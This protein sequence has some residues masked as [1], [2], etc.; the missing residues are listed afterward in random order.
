MRRKSD[1]NSLPTAPVGFLEEA[2]GVRSATRLVM[3]GLLLLATCVT[4]TLCAYVLFIP[5]P[6]T[7]TAATLAAAL[8]TLV[9]QGAVAVAK[10]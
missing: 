9:V 4:L 3:L 5:A 7:G 10:R 6:D 1:R 8:A 2:P